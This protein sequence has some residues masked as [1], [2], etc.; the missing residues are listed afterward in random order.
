MLTRARGAG[1]RRSEIRVIGGSGLYALL[2]PD[3]V[4]VRHVRYGLQ[5]EQQGS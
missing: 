3:G 5:R 4:G 2:D 1:V